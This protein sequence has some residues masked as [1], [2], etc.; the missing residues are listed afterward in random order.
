M[1][2]WFTVPICPPRSYPSEWKM[3]V[4]T[5]ACLLPMAIALGHVFAPLRLPFIVNVALSTVIPVS[6]LTWVIRPRLTSVLFRWLYATR[7]TVVAP[8]RSMA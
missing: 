4:L 6:M 7:V 2:T 3:P 8:H 5:W 1:Q